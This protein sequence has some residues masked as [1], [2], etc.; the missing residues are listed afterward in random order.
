MRLAGSYDL[1]SATRLGIV[2]SRNLLSDVPGLGSLGQTIRFKLIEIDAGGQR[3][4]L[5]TWK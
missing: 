5:L 2:R 1:D 4:L 3:W